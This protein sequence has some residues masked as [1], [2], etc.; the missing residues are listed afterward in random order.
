MLTVG[1]PTKVPSFDHPCHIFNL[2]PLDN[3]KL[4]KSPSPFFKGGG[5]GE[6][7]LKLHIKSQGLVFVESGWLVD[8]HAPDV[9]T[10]FHTNPHPSYLW[11][12]FLLLS[13]CAA[14]SVVC[15]YVQCFIANVVSNYPHDMTY[16]CLSG[17]SSIWGSDGHF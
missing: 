7:M 3:P 14:L 11:P 6:A 1:S 5:G 9:P 15:W 4:R 12:L 17:G 8:A 16:N 10:Y 13:C 2:L